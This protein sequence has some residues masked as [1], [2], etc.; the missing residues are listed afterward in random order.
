M[1]KFLPWVALDL[2][3]AKVKFGYIS[4]CMG[5]SENFVLLETIAAIG[6]KVGL[7]IQINELMKLNEYQSQG[8][9]LTLAKGHSDFKVKTCFSRKLL[10]HLEPNEN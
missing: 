5:K 2:F 8:H 4:L 6:L 3:Y 7:N 10:S 1:F 9:Y